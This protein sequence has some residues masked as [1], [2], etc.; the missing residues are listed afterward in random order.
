MKMPQESTISRPKI[1]IE[2]GIHEYIYKYD[3]QNK[4]E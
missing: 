4:A 1:Y 3:K 2:L